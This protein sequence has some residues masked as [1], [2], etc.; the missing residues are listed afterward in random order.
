MVISILTGTS[1]LVC[2]ALMDDEKD[3]RRDIVGIVSIN[4][5]GGELSIAEWDDWFIGF[6]GPSQDPP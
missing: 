5:V 3:G 1:P 2:W 4:E 6:L